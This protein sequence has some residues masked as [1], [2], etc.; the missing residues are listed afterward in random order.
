MKLLLTQSFVLFSLICASGCAVTEQVYHAAPSELSTTRRE[1]KT[2]G[3]WIAQHPSPN[4]IV[5]TSDE[6]A[7]FNRRVQDDLKLTRDI[8][9]LPEI[10]G[11]DVAKE[12]EE[13]IRQFRKA[14]YYGADGRKER[15]AFYDELHALMRV[16]IP[17]KITPAFGM[18]VH[19]ADQRILPTEKPLYAKA[20]DIDFD[21][22]QNSTLDVGTP[23]AVLSSSSD[24]RWY[25]AESSLSAGW[26]RKEDVALTDIGLLQ[27]NRR[28]QGFVVVTDAKTDIF[29]N[30]DMTDYYDY[31]RMGT[32]FR[33]G[34]GIYDNGM[35]SIWVPLRTDDGSLTFQEGFVKQSDVHEGYLPYTARNIITQAFELLNA[36]YGWGG[37]YGEQDCSAFL[38]E[39][40]AT[41]GIVLPRN[42][43]AQ[44]QAGK[45]LAE[46]RQETPD[47]EKMEVLRSVPGGTT[48]LGLKGHIMLYL[49]MID[50][51]PYAIHAVWAYREPAGKNRDDRVR[52]I[53]RV[54]VTG[55]QLGEG[56]HKGSLLKRLT[57]IGAVTK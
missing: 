4:D 55:L 27:D 19:Y 6:I 38:D 15:G 24:D 11:A 32:K 53:N 25:Y 49:G 20:G 9:N 21:E 28:D 8:L 34:E 3:F 18:V 37:M 16:N 33:I 35:V 2:A 41:A 1:M 12:W 46:F 54:A 56:S 43:S 44:R 45:I 7:L 14:G 23:V 50:A 47:P 10:S 26:I 40:F 57:E 52:V 31:A 51:R 48:L 17:L 13:T 39:V 29:L 30:S 42:S 5:M 36:P 22:L